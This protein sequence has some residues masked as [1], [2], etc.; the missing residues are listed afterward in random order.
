MHSF[1]FFLFFLLS[2]QKFVLHKCLGDLLTVGACHWS[3]H[4]YSQGLLRNQV[5]LF[6]CWNSD[7]FWKIN[8]GVSSSVIW[9]NCN[10]FLLSC[11]VMGKALWW[12][13]KMLIGLKDCIEV[14]SKGQYWHT[15]TLSWNMWLTLMQF[16]HMD[17][18]PGSTIA[19]LPVRALKQSL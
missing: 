6:Q 4:W 2:Y 9:R 7:L 19:K 1:I 14:N 8:L 3:C 18:P 12:S 16:F 17:H 5:F 13:W 15:V 10:F 11:L